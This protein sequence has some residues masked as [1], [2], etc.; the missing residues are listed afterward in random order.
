M[1]FAESG[2]KIEGGLL[3]DTRAASLEEG[4][5]P[6]HCSRERAE[7]LLLVAM[8]HEDPDLEMP[9]KSSKLPNELLSDFEA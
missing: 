3:L 1:P 4:Y 5:R 7:S 8:R 9:P 6:C 2:V